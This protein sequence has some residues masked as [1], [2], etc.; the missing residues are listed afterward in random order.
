MAL[1]MGPHWPQQQPQRLHLGAAAAAAAA[2]FAALTPAAVHAPP[3]L[4]LAP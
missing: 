1:P 4:A 2:V 3:E